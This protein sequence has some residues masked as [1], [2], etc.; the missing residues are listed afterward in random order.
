MWL[1]RPVETIWRAT[2]SLGLAGLVGT[3]AGAIGGLLIAH[4]NPEYYLRI[5]EL[6]DGAEFSVMRIGLA[7][8]ALQGSLAG[9]ALG[10]VI[11]AIASFYGARHARQE[12]APHDQPWCHPWRAAA[13]VLAAGVLVGGPVGLYVASTVLNDRGSLT[14]ARTYAERLQLLDDAAEAST[15]PEIREHQFP[16]GERITHVSRDSHGAPFLD[17]GTVVVRDSNG[18]SRA[19]YGHGCGGW[20]VSDSAMARPR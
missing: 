7:L 2:R 1:L 15:D 14:L 10:V 9:A 6:A 13:L 8:G 16:S 3:A 18:T 12:W 17:G 20:Y 19:F 11:F 5:F 4:F